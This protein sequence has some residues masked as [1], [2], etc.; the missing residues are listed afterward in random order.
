MAS[1]AAFAAG[2]FAR[3]F[4]GIVLSHYGDRFG[5][6]RVF[7]MS[8]FVMSAATLGMGLVPTFAQWGIAASALVVTLR[9][10]QG[11]LPRR[12]TSWRSHLRRRNRAAH[13]ALRL[14][15]RIRLR[16][17]GRRSG[18]RGEPVGACTISIRRWCRLMDGALRSC[19]VASA[20][21]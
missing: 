10:I 12:R 2:Y 4:G 16:D 6:R 9:L 13:R 5:R 11:V 21:C 8:L 20:A 15:R 7:L 14:W 18:D 1:F 19:L 3:P 17:D